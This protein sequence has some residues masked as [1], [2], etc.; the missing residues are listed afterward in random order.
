MIAVWRGLML[1]GAYDAANERY[2]HG[3]NEYRRLIGAMHAD[4]MPK[5]LF[6]NPLV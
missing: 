5:I 6:G 3:H 2:S 4:Q 1:Y